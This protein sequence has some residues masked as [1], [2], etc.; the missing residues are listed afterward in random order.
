MNA[1]EMSMRMDLRRRRAEVLANVVMGKLRDAIPYDHQKDVYYAI[2]EVFHQEGVEIITD[3]TR[4]EAGLS[5]RGHEGWTLEELH[6]LEEKRLEALRRPIP[7]MMPMEVLVKESD[8]SLESQR[9]NNQTVKK[10]TGI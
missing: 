9:A 2:L 5:P 10:Y 6:A 4:Q 8:Q 3:Y 7:Y 1:Y